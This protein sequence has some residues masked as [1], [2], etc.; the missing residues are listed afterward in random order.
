MAEL[1]TSVKFIPIL[2]QIQA[3]VEAGLSYVMVTTDFL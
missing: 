2:R 3:L 1:E